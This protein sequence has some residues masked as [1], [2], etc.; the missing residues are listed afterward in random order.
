[1]SSITDFTVCKV[2]FLSAVRR[3]QL[4]VTWICDIVMSFNGPC[5]LSRRGKFTSHLR[6]VSFGAAKLISRKICQSRMP[7]RPLH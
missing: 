6:S 1:M 4:N 2:T 5:A 7:F 3:S